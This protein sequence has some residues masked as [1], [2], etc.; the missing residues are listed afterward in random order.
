MHLYTQLYTLEVLRDHLS[1]A[2]QQPVISNRIQI[3]KQ[4]RFR[5]FHREHR[6][7]L[8][9]AC[10]IRGQEHNFFPQRCNTW[11]NNGCYRN[12]RKG[13]QSLDFFTCF[14]FSMVWI[15]YAGPP[16]GVLNQGTCVAWSADLDHASPISC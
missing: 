3:N 9:F 8:A 1:L 5:L 4:M 11:F 15:R 14:E 12:I 6:I 7:K 10:L 2:K 13:V 16:C